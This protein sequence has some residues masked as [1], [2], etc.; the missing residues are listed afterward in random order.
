MRDVISHKGTVTEMT[1]Q[2]TTVV[3]L[4]SSACGVCH[5]AGFC[6]MAELAEKT[7]QVPSDPYATYKVGDEVEVLLKATMG[8]KAV[9]LGYCIPAVI[10]LAVVLGL[11]ALGVGEVTAALASLGAIALYYL[12]LWLCRG[13]LQ[14]EYIFT[15]KR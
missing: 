9:W 7:I 8:F 5:A 10:L 6:G 3:I 14:N 12:L 11:L 13:K 15:I 1:P 2:A 4:S